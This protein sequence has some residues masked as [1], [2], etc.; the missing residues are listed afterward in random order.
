[1]SGLSGASATVVLTGDHSAT[2]NVDTAGYYEFTSLRNGTYGVSIQ[3]SGFSLSPLSRIVEIAYENETDVDFIATSSSADFYAVRGSVYGAVE[4]GV[5][6]ELSG[7]ATGEILTGATGNFAFLQ[8]ENGTYTLTP[9]LTG[10]AFTPSSTIVTV[11]GADVVGLDF[12]STRLNQFSITGNVSID[13]KS[14]V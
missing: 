10:Y 5:M 11:N 6:I 1:M 12:S 9:V 7:D 3:T 13:R 8:V 14:V 2:V 4:S